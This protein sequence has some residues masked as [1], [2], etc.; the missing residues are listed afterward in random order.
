MARRFSLARLVELGPG[1]KLYYY[2]LSSV[3]IFLHVRSL[4]R[5]SFLLNQQMALH[6]N[7]LVK[8]RVQKRRGCGYENHADVVGA[9]NVLERGYRLLALWRVGAARPL[10]EA[11]TH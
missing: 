1:D 2:P 8:A 7:T 4:L 6:E 3:L 9:I 11:G 5:I 10:N